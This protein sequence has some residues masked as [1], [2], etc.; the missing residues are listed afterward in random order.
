MKKSILLV[1]LAIPAV[2]FAQVKITEIFYDA[3][4]A[5][6]GRE[7]IEIQ[8]VSGADVDLSKFKL[9][10]SGTNHGLRAIGNG[11]TSPSAFAVIV[12]NTGLF[13]EDN[14]NFQGLIFDSTFSLSNTG[15]SLSIKNP[16][17]EIVDSVTYKADGNSGS[18][19]QL[20]NGNWVSSKP[21]P[22]AENKISIIQKTTPIV[23]EKSAPIAKPKV[24]K[25]STII[26]SP[27][28]NDEFKPTKMIPPVEELP[29]NEKSS[30]WV[31]IAGLTTVIAG[32]LFGLFFIENKGQKNEEGKKELSADDFEIIEEKEE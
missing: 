32:G 17:G 19:L 23:P 28:K 13:K 26:D 5:D 21:T 25:V 9:F 6:G 14:P 15:E 4:G 31:Y 8:N 24:T 30:L 12:A 3:T 1:F 7:W 29:S 10:E 18:S 22:D 27:T 16:K 2:S 20:I 11:T